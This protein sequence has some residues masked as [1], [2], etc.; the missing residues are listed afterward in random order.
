MGARTILV[1]CGLLVAAGCR[2]LPA[3]GSAERDVRVLRCVEG[4]VVDAAGVKAYQLM[5]PDEPRTA[6]VTGPG[7]PHLALR[8][9]AG[10]E[11]FELCGHFHRQ[12]F[13]DITCGTMPVFVAESFRPLAPALR[14]ADVLVPHGW[15]RSL[16]CDQQGFCRIASFRWSYGTISRFVAGLT[17]R[18]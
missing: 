10:V 15:G 2:P 7:A 8:E 9:S 14:A 13:E 17:P 16:Q 6:Y 18:R 1:M 11:R 5:I 12:G 4:R 3:P